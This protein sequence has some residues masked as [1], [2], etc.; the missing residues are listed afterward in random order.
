MHTALMHQAE[1]RPSI[2]IWSHYLIYLA[3]KVGSAPS[4]LK[5]IASRATA[6]RAE[7]AMCGGKTGAV[8]ARERAGSGAG[9]GTGTGGAEET[10]GLGAAGEAG[11]ATGGGGGV[12]V[13]TGSGGCWTLGST[14]RTP[15]FDGKVSWRNFPLFPCSVCFLKKSTTLRSHVAGIGRKC[16]V[17]W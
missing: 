1:R 10:W 9:A 8:A 11:S 13:S 17:A 14:N 15:P 12:L 5:S 6:A 2:P 4:P 16:E 7:A 3:S